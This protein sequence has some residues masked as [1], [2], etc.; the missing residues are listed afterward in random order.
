MIDQQRPLELSIAHIRHGQRPSVEG[1]HT[2]GDVP[3]DKLSVV[4]SQLRQMLATRQ[5]PEMAVK[6]QQ[7][8][9]LPIVFQFVRAPVSILQCERH[10][11]L[12]DPISR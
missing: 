8:P 7:Q 9:T 5:S 6:D 3:F 1:N 10:G 11:R 2:N 4:L 12:T